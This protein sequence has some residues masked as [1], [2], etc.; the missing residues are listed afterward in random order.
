MYPNISEP[1]LLSFQDKIVCKHVL[2]CV[3]DHPNLKEGKVE[4]NF[5]VDGQHG[6]IKMKNCVPP[7]KQVLTQLEK[8]ND[9]HFIFA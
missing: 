6:E 3:Q 7:K 9:E 8:A 5:L 2:K 1:L 4:I